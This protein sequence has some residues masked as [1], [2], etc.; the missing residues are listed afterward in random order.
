MKALASFQ[1]LYV[2]LEPYRNDNQLFGGTLSKTSPAVFGLLAALELHPTNEKAGVFAPV[3]GFEVVSKA[4]EDLALDLGVEIYYNKNVESIHND[5]ISYSTNNGF[6]DKECH[7]LPADCI[8]VNAD[9][10][11]SKTTLIKKDNDTSESDEKEQQ[12]QPKT[13]YDW[14]DNFD[15]S[16]GVLAFYWAVDKRCESLNTHNVFLISSDRSKMEKSWSAVRY[17]D[18]EAKSFEDANF[19]F[20]FYVHRASATDESAAPHGCDSLMILVPCCTLRRD[21][22]LATLDR[23]ECIK[24]YREQFDDEFVSKVRGRILDRLSVLDD[25]DD[26]QSHILDE[27][28]VT[29]ADYA[30][31][32]NLGAGTP[33]ALSHGFGQ[34][35]LTRPGQQARDSDNI[36][37]VG[38]STRPGNGVPLV[39]LGAKQVAKKAISKIKTYA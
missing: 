26:I 18:P 16:S 10:P 20:N 5:G 35:S 39:L 28:Y 22:N 37:F 31:Y 3:G 27:V 15:F 29:P 23:D 2:G 33:F 17:N 38:A 11:Y 21:E 19:P 6:D 32:Y 8:I 34:L 9:L 25:L 36:L 4:F 24:G 7:F 12:Q 13:R 14:D 30:N 1:N